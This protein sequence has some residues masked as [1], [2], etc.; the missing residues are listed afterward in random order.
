MIKVLVTGVFDILHQEHISF[1]KKAKAAGDFLIVALETD[2]RTR[3]L[4]GKGRPV[5]NLKT[6]IL[7]LQRLSIADQVIPLP[8]QFDHPKDH[9]KFLEEIKPDILAISSHT[10]N[11]LQKLELMHQ[12]GGEL[13]IVHPHNPEVSTTRMVQSNK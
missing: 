4:K 1:L 13:Q 6:R 8:E 5:N 12:I 11:Q 10:P 2:A 7:N 3:H 9:L